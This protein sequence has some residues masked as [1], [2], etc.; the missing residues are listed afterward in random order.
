MEQ[1]LWG[2]MGYG[3][4]PRMHDRLLGGQAFQTAATSE[5]DKNWSLGNGCMGAAT[6]KAGLN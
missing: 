4:H 5:R 2:A 3:P 1:P 6:P